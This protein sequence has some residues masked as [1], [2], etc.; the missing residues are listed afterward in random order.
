MLTENGL[1]ASGGLPKLLER[2]ADGM[3]YGALPKCPECKGQLDIGKFGR[4]IRCKGFLSEWTRCSFK[5]PTIERNDWI[6]PGYHFP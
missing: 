4:D 2:C 5:T 6:I 1:E 3:M